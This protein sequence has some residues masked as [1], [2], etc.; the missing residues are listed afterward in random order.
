MLNAY[1]DIGSTSLNRWFRDRVLREHRNVSALG[2]R[3]DVSRGSLTNWLS[4]A[5]RIPQR[6][7]G[8]LAREFGEDPRRIAAL[9][10]ESY[11]PELRNALLPVIR[12]VLAAPGN[13]C[14]G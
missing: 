14:D 5:S 6:Y 1:H 2:R 4:G 11:E 13:R 8:P 10:L 12:T 3:L 7:I 9:Y